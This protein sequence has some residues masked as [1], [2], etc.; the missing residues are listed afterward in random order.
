M[1][2]L[3][4][5]LLHLL[6]RHMTTRFPACKTHVFS[7]QLSCPLQKLKER[8]RPD[9]SMHLT[10]FLRIIRPSCCSGKKERRNAI[11]ISSGDFTPCGGTFKRFIECAAP[12]LATWHICSENGVLMMALRFFFFALSASVGGVKIS[13]MTVSFL[14]FGMDMLSS[15]HTIAL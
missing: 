14:I 8:V 9:F 6:I 3:I 12:V 13:C 4:L 5:F 7:A 10:C 1:A 2:L 11:M 15:Q